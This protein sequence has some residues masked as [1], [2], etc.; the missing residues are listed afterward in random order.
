MASRAPSAEIL[1]KITTHSECSENLLAPT[2]K[3]S[4]GGNQSGCP[5]PDDIEWSDAFFDEQSHGASSV[6]GRYSDRRKKSE[7]SD[8]STHGASGEISAFDNYSA[9]SLYGESRA[10]GRLQR[11]RRE[12]TEDYLR[13][14]RGSRGLEPMV[15][16][17][18][19]VKA[20]Y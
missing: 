13:K 3:N 1:V 19:L 7:K 5:L 20:V 9:H 6:G 10:S 11:I 8:P 12:E 16:H 4:C 2:N 17:Y 14:P 18:S 15:E